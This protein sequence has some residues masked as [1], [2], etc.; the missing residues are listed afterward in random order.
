MD[1]AN[2]F[3]QFFSCSVLGMGFIPI[4]N[5]NVLIAHVCVKGNQYF[6]SM[7]FKCDEGPNMQASRKIIVQTKIL[8]QFAFSFFFSFFTYIR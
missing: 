7:P 8:F 4:E 2:L 1:F 6:D 3:G 5:R